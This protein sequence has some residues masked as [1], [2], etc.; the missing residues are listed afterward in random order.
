MVKF[1]QQ[2]RAKGFNGAISSTCGKEL[3]VRSV[4]HCISQ[5]DHLGPISEVDDSVI[6][7]ND[8]PV[9]VSVDNGSDSNIVGTY[10]MTLDRVA[11]TSGNRYINFNGASKS[12]CFAKSSSL[13]IIKHQTLIITTQDKWRTTNVTSRS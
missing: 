5:P 12:R 9:K 8:S 10:L 6:I 11:H 2:T 13:D 1:S 3:L 7:I 4:E